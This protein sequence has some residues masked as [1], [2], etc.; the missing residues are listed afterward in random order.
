MNA[1]E[2]PKPLGAD[3]H[4]WGI[5][6]ATRLWTASVCFI[7]MYS[8]FLFLKATGFPRRSTACYGKGF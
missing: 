4:R 7:T 3:V 2:V 1:Q 5:W 6:K 8:T